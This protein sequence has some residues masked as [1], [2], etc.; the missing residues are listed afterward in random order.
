[1]PGSRA[2]GGRRGAAAGRGCA[3]LRYLCWDST[4]RE[5][6]SRQL[7]LPLV[8]ESAERA[9]QSRLQSFRSRLRGEAGEDEAPDADLHLRTLVAI[10]AEIEVRLEIALLRLGQRTVE[11]KV[12]RTSDIVTK[13]HC[14]P[15]WSLR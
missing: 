2:A 5:S 12:N 15:S 4:R 6:A 13:H 10:G 3:R 11:E 9:C 14:F 7:A 8:A 1:M